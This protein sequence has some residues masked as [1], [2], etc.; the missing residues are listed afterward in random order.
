MEPPSLGAHW[1]PIHEGKERYPLLSQLSLS[2]FRRTIG[3][4]G[5]ATCEYGQGAGIKA[6]QTGRLASSLGGTIQL[7]RTED[8]KGDLFYN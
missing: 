4:Q 6:K 8:C 5:R 1:A 2:K 7:Y 3:S